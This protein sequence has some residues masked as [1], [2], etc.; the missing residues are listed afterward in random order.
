ME[1]PTRFS[2]G[3]PAVRGLFRRFCNE[4]D[5]GRPREVAMI[6]QF[7]GTGGYHPNERRHTACLLLPEVGVVFDA[8]TG[9]FRIRERLR[10]PDIQLFLT[11]A[12]LDHVVGLTY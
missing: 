6:L 3:F 4:R 5:V 12:H 7:L 8:G 2:D 1:S 11:H 9:A 10:T